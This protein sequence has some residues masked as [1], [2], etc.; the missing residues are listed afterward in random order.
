MNLAWLKKINFPNFGRRGQSLMEVIIALAIFALLAAVMVSLTLGGFTSLIQGGDYLA[1]AALAD[2]GLEAVRSIRD[3]AWNELVFTQSVAT[4]T[5][6]QWR[7][8]GEGT[9][10]TVGQFTRTTS[11]APVCRDATRAIVVCP[12]GTID[13]ESQTA[14]VMVSW[15]AASGANNEVE[16]AT[17]FTNWDSND[18]VQTDWS[19]GA[20]QVSWSDPTRYLSDDGRLDQTGGELKLRSRPLVWVNE[21]S[22]TTQTLNDVHC[23][24]ANDCFA[25]GNAITG[26]PVANQGE[27]ILHWN[28]SAW[29]RVSPSASIPNVNLNSVFCVSAGDCLAV[30]NASGGE[31]IIRNT[32]GTGWTR[33]NTV[34]AIPDVGL[35]SIFCLT[36]NDCW[37]VG[38][39][40]G[41]P[42]TLH[43]NGSA[44]SRIGPAPTAPNVNLNSVWCVSPN[45]CWAVGGSGAIV[46][47][48]GASWNSFINFGSVTWNSVFLLTANDG[49]VAGTNGQIRRWN[50]G[51]WNTVYSTGG[52]TWNEVEGSV[53]LSG[54]VVGANGTRR[55]FDG[56]N[57]NDLLTGTIRT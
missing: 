20:G 47:W 31:L 15:S 54:L 28:G 25:V 52:Q 57:W 41:G 10:E 17:L 16:R 53:G 39:R 12:A 49:W 55:Q 23:R 13:L 42:L 51:N 35:N 14:R 24:S 32:G 46:R 43:W 40:S 48:N 37:V 22:P 38:I 4:S 7:F 26:G 45:D 9:T 34:A 21:I 44:W 29:S 18:W 36:N 5:S 3:G 6:G 33:F 8:L 11:F 2:E 50:G 56:T 19:G 27:M 30:G 1:A